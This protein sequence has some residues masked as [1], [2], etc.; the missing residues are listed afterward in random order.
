MRVYNWVGGADPGEAQLRDAANWEFSWE[1]SSTAGGMEMDPDI[2]PNFSTRYL[3]EFDRQLGPKWAVKVRGVYSSARDLTEDIAV[4]DPE[5]QWGKW[6]YTNFELKRRDYK[7]LEFELNGKVAGRFM[8][9][10]SYT[11]SQARGT[12][13]GNTIE[14]STWGPISW[15]GPRDINFFGDHADVP[16]D[17]PNKELLDYLFGGLGGRGV[18][19][20]GWYGLL[21]YSVDHQVKVLGIYNAPY[22]IVVSSGIEYL[23]GYHWDKRG[24]GGNGLYMTFPEGRGGRTTPGHMYVDLAVEKEVRLRAGMTLGLGLN[25]YNLLNGQRPV[26]YVKEDAALFGQVWARQLPRWVQLKARIRF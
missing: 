22:G 8:L 1:Q 25:V 21:P 2:R 23:S 20:E 18:G 10:A 11:W 6:I 16:A 14:L 5:A 7:A 4:Y 26:S 17:S 12:Q 15:G 19:D 3:L 24:L 9:N 13:S